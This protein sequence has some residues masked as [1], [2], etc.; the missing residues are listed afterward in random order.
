M[1]PWAGATWQKLSWPMGG[2]VRVNDPCNVSWAEGLAHSTVGTV[3]RRGTAQ[4]HA[5]MAWPHRVS[6]RHDTVANYTRGM[7]R[8]AVWWAA[9]AFWAIGLSLSWAAAMRDMIY[10]CGFDRLFLRKGWFPLL[11][12]TPMAVPDTGGSKWWQSC[13]LQINYQFLIETS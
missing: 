1:V 8:L 7:P 13:L 6:C 2:T 3:A 12:G 9:E 5:G 11:L 4:C 10:N